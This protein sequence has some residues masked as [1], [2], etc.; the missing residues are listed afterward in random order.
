MLPTKF[1]TFQKALAGVLVVSTLVLLVVCVSPVYSDWNG[2]IDDITQEL[3]SDFKFG[4]KEDVKSENLRNAN[5]QLREDVQIQN[6]ENNTLGPLSGTYT[7]G[8]LVFTYE[9][10]KSGKFVAK[11][12]SI[13]QPTVA[14]SFVGTIINNHS[15]FVVTRTETTGP[16]TNF[17]E[18]CSEST[19][20]TGVFNGA[21]EAGTT[22]SFSRDPLCSEIGILNPTH[23]KQ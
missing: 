12:T 23:T 15:S 7:V 1:F 6:N 14:I 8:N 3:D 4:G 9:V 5:E 10:F 19:S 16:P 2:D 18:A 11:G 13:G 21:G 22:H 20:V 17:P